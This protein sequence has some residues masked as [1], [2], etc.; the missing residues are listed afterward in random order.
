MTIFSK[1]TKR[2]KPSSKTLRFTLI[3]QGKTQ[4]QI[5]KTGI[6]NQDFKRAE[7]YVIVKQIFVDTTLKSIK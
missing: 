3:P 7:E 5:A 4:E 1:F 6:L 2:Y